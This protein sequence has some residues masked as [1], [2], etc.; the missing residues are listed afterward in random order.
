[1]DPD[2]QKP[3]PDKQKPDPD[4]KEPVPDKQEP[5][6]DKKEPDLDKQEPDPDK[7]EP[8]PDLILH[9]KNRQQN[10]Q[11]TNYNVFSSSCKFNMLSAIKKGTKL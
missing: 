10:W 8:D 1:M 9:K 4:K 11:I 5:D 7:Q 2:K 3:D 6:P